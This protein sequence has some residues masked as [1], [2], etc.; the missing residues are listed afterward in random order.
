MFSIDY[1][2]VIADTSALKATWLKRHHDLELPYYRLDKAGIVSLL[3]ED[4]FEAMVE[5][6]AG[7]RGSLRASPVPGAAEALAR[8]AR[9]G[10]VYVVT[11]RPEERGDYARE[12]L[13]AQGLQGFVRRV[14]AAGGRPKW[15]VARALGCV[16]HVDDDSRHLSGFSKH[17]IAPFLLSRGADEAFLREMQKGPLKGLGATIC[18][19]WEQTADALIAAA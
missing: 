9:R 19:A 11:A 10:P 5:A 17:G 6:C 7:R 2:G 12:W 1:D 3:G 4:G 13:A 8:L 18:P 16:A 14:L 15:R